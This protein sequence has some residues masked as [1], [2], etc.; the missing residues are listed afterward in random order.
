VSDASV[1]RYAI[2][3]MVSSVDGR[4]LE[5]GGAANGAFDKISLVICPAVDGTKGAPN[6]FDPTDV[7]AGAAAPLRA[8]TLQR[9]EVLED[10]AV[11]LR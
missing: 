2:C 9:S 8:I 4:I 11:W 1:K 6:V 3:H 10:G 5:G 7:D